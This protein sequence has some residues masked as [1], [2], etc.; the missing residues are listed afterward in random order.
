MIQE[1][2]LVRLKG[3][4]NWVGD[5]GLACWVSG[6]GALSSVMPPAPQPLVFP[7]AARVHTA[8]GVATWG[9]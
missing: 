1:H 2:V 4:V 9:H 8:N 7:A 6:G 5:G 3:E